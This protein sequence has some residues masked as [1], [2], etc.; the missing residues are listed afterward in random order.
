[1]KL[2]VPSTVVVLMYVLLSTFTT[3]FVSFCIIFP[4]SSLTVKLNVALFPVLIST[5][6]TVMFSRSL[7]ITIRSSTVHLCVL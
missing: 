1:M 7:L 5:G 4:Y 3:I 2:T 6:V